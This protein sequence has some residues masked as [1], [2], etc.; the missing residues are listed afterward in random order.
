MKITAKREFFILLVFFLLPIFLGS[1][2]YFIKPDYF[3][4]KT[5]NNGELL[6]PIIVAEKEHI[7]FTDKYTLQNFWTLIY[8]DNSCDAFCNQSLKDIEQIRLLT[9]DDMLRVQRVAIIADKTKPLKKDK[10]LIFA[11]IVNA[12]LKQ[13]LNKYPV[14]SIFLADPIGN[15][16]LYYNPKNL[17][18]SA[19]VSD[20]SRLLKYSRIG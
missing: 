17:D 9:N 15:I 10:D 18:I 4:K 12:E 8:F 16:I 13:K 2:I 20:L 11:T 19:V 6:D 7:N 3:S 5:I 14:R 1:L